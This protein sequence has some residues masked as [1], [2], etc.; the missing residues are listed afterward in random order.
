M[1]IDSQRN[2]DTS[3]TH[4]S[5]PGESTGTST[6]IEATNRSSSKD[7]NPANLGVPFKERIRPGMVVSWKKT[8]DDGE[9]SSTPDQS[10]LAVVLSPVKGAEGASKETDSGSQYI[11]AVVTQGVMTGAYEINVWRQI[12][13]HIESMENEVV[14]EYDRSTRYY[15]IS[16]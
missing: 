3:N 7:L 16:V 6:P 14:L 15:Y 1:H 4:T 8:S 9:E 12:I 13:V 11:C 10:N 5:N 2:A